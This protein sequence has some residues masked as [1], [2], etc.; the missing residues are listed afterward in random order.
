MQS[1]FLNGRSDTVVKDLMH[2]M[3]TASESQA[4]EQAV[5]YRDQIAAIK[6][7]QAQQSMSSKASTEADA[8]AAVEQGGVFCV[9]TV[10]V[11]RGSVLGSRSWFPR[12]P[13]GSDA[14]EVIHAFIS[15]HYFSREVPSEIL[16]NA[17]PGDAELIGA[18]LTEQAG[19]KVRIKAQVRGIRKDWVAMAATNAREALITRLSS[20]ASMR[21]QREELA[22]VLGL[23]EPPTRMECFDISHTSG[24]ET[25]ASC[26]VFGADGPTKNAYRR[27]NIKNVTPGDDYAAIGQVVE[28]RYKRSSERGGFISGP[29]V[30]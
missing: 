2:R 28:R 4:Y 15:Q 21:N 5:E 13:K 30:Y 6:Q 26:V 16:V 25:V 24:K 7:V 22:A 18:S 3:E 27:F 8:L 19:H 20:N 12:T 9:V 17:L 29:R 10:M 1:Y 11:R 23:G 14:A